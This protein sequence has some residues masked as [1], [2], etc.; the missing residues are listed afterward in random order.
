MQTIRL[1]GFSVILSALT[2]TLSLVSFGQSTPPP[3]AKKIVGVWIEDQTKRK[4]GSSLGDLRFR[5]T[6]D[7]GIEELRGFELQPLVEKV[8]FDTKPYVID[9]S[10]TIAWKKVDANHFERKLY[11]KGKLQDTRRI[12]IS[13]DGKTLTEVTED[14]LT[15][16]KKGLIA[17]TFQR[18]SDG[19]Q[20]LVGVWKPQSMKMT[21][22]AEVRYEL[23]ATGGLK[24]TD[25]RGVNQT[26]MLDNVPVGVNGGTVI[27]GTMV[28]FKVIDDNTLEST[29]TRAGVVTGR[30]TLK[31]SNDGKT[32]TATTTEVDPNGSREPSVSVFDKH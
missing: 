2:L 15:N 32:L 22:A 17:V 12:Q 29:S 31:I 5:Q 16:G 3:V 23:T 1:F 28:A 18:N 20:G 21:P 11:D 25:D 14:V 8:T 27:S 26:F 9:E 19:P 4:I 24:S 10:S 30:T 13:E 7:G 6:T